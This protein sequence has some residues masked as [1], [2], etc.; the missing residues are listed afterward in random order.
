MLFFLRGY[1][2]MAAVAVAAAVAA[3]VAPCIIV[4]IKID[5]Y[6]VLI[7]SV[8]LWYALSFPQGRAA[9][10]RSPPDGHR[11]GPSEQQPRWSFRMMVTLASI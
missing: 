11:P 6:P 7:I 10:R 4:L 2:V 3:T 1:F 8:M 5:G 9:Q